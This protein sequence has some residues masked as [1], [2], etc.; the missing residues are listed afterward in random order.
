MRLFSFLFNASL[1]MISLLS[2]AYAADNDTQPDNFS[3]WLN[4]FAHEAY[5]KGISQKTLQDALT[6]VHFNARV[7]ELDK[8]Q[9]HATLTFDDYLQRIVPEQRIQRAR[10]NFQENRALLERIGKKYNVQPR[11]I[12]ALWGVESDFG[13]N[14]GGFE[15][16][17]ALATLAYEG[18]RAEFFKKELFNALTI[19]D[20]GHISVH[21]MKGS[22]AGAMGQTQFMPSSFL[23]LAVDENGDGKRDI[24]GTKE[25][26]F[27]SIA[28]YL[29]KRGW[30]DDTTWGRRVL[31]PAKLESNLLEKKAY[32]LVTWHNAGLKTS[33][34]T[35]LPQ[36]AG[37]EARLVNPGEDKNHLYLVYPNYDTIL[38]WN[39]ST[40][41]ATGVGILS[42]AIA[43][44]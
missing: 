23:E 5:E 28:N 38:T 21:D 30:S 7:I 8:K 14:M 9:P 33:Y 4:R 44:R 22:W 26:V 13:R 3:L 34:G 16:I 19:I 35:P 25:D 1:I 10:K 12:V 24:W 6:D 37:L 32:P 18:R 11:F 27:G 29:S 17:G 20:Q 41:F 2:V 42:D 40:Y 15:I 36:R 39:R 31:V 43:Q